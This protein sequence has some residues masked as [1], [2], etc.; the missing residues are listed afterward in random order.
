[1]LTYIKRK[2]VV[3][4]YGRL[5][6]LL[7]FVNLSGDKCGSY[8]RQTQNVHHYR[9]SSLTYNTDLQN[10]LSTC[11]IH[12]HSQTHLELSVKPFGITASQ[13]HHLW[14][15]TSC[16]YRVH[17]HGILTRCLVIRIIHS[18]NPQVQLTSQVDVNFSIRTN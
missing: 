6:A 9:L 17:A 4:L 12:I 2:P 5:A 13:T 8:D 15:H 3:Y 16:N 1:M 10:D 7:G 14:I 18:H 11:Q